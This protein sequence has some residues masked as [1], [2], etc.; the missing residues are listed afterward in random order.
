MAEEQSE[1]R[2]DARTGGQRDGGNRR[3]Q[4][5][6]RPGGPRPGGEGFK[7]FVDPE[8]ER[9]FKGLGIPV[10][11]QRKI[12]L[13]MERNTRVIL[14][15]SPYTHTLLDIVKQVDRAAKNVGNKVMTVRNP[16]AVLAALGK[17]QDA[18]TVFDVAAEE[19]VR[20]TGLPYDSP[21]DRG[22]GGGDNGG[23]LRDDAPPVDA[24]PARGKRR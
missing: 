20:S 10:P 14:A 24:P 2:R 21:V 3:P 11:M 5:G 6:Q 9:L 19:F 12:G 7:P 22:A 18:V 13:A 23:G 8:K 1:V 15:R 17:F 4:G 16:Q